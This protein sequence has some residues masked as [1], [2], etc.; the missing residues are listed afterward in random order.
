MKAWFLRF[1]LREQVALLVML[2][3]LA[4]Y[5]ALFFLV[6]PQGRARAQLAAINLATADTLTEVDAWA[7]EIRALRA[8]GGPSARSSRPGLS[9]LLNESASRYALSI[10]RLQPNS[11]GA[12]QLRLESAP[13]EALLR[14]IHYLEYSENLVL[15]ELSLGQTSS[16]G[17]VSATLRVAALN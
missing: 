2:A 13:L 4:I 5:V 3:A 9:A 15:E 16:A 11:R 1:S 7:A 14:W 10:S 8:A 6:L 12:V 17:V